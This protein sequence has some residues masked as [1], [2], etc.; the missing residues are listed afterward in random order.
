MTSRAAKPAPRCTHCGMKGTKGLGSL[1]YV[2]FAGLRHQHCRN[3]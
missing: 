3:A 2:A 1:I